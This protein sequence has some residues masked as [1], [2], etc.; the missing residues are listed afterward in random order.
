MYALGWHDLKLKTIIS[1]IGHTLPGAASVRKRHKIVVI[2]GEETTIRRDKLIK[3]PKMI[4]DFF[5]FFSV[6]DVHDHL[7]Q[8]SLRME[9]AWKTKNWV[10][11]LFATMFGIILTDCYLAYNLHNTHS[12]SATRVSYAIFLGR[13]CKQMCENDPQRLS[14]RSSS[15]DPWLETPGKCLNHTCMQLIKHPFY[16]DLCGTGQKA[17]IRCRVAGCGKKTGTYCVTCSQFTHKELSN[18]KLRIFGVFGVCSTGT[19]RDCYGQH[20]AMYKVE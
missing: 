11:R 16:S 6:I 12:S 8:G 5:E 20:L 4:E 9:E 19:G 18:D 10:H 14:R 15:E 1:N 13:L 3:R 2:D 7:R 17:R